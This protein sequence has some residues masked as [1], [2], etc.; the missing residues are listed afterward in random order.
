MHWAGSGPGST[1][2]PSM[3]KRVLDTHEY[4]PRIAQPAPP[5]ALPVAARPAGL[6]PGAPH[7]GAAPTG[8]GVTRVGVGDF[9]LLHGS[10]K[11][12][13]YGLGSCVALAWWDPQARLAG[14]LHAVLPTAEGHDG[15][16]V[17]SPYRFVDTGLAL[18]LRQ[19]AAEGGA[20]ARARFGLFGAASMPGMPARFNVGGRNLLSLRKLAW[21]LNLRIVADETEGSISR[22]LCLTCPSGLVVL[23][24]PGLPNRSF[25]L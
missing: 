24:S 5:P 18:A 1:G 4:R 7:A 13:T 14:L 15:V 3:N 23:T 25:Q 6:R 10:G 17:A 11:L 20:A 8:D 21:H 2:V 19:F 12:M 16:S 22:T 9:G